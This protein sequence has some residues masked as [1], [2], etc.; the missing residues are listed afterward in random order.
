[1]L[2]FPLMAPSALAEADCPTSRYLINLGQLEPF[3]ESLVVGNQEVLHN[4]SVM[5][6]LLAENLRSS[7]WPC[8][9][10]LGKREN[11]ANS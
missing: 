4:L 7:L 2:L 11:A 5:D 1:M 8:F 6:K 10:T 3:L 9:L